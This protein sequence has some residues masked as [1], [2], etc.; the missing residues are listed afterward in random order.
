MYGVSQIVPHLCCYCGGAVGSIVSVF[1]QFYRSGFNFEFAT[2]FSK[3]DKWL[4]IYV[5]ENAKEWLLKNS[6]FIVLQQCQN[7]INFKERT[8]ASYLNQMFTTFFKK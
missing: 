5:R 7:R 8:L 6:T 3:S 4:L 2:L 1:T